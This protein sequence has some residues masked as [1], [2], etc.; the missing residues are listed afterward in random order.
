MTCL[1]NVFSCP[2]CTNNHS[3]SSN[4]SRLVCNNCIST[5]GISDK[6]GNKLEIVINPFFT[7]VGEYYSKNKECYINKRECYIIV[8]DDFN[9]YE[10]VCTIPIPN[11]KGILRNE[12][13]NYQDTLVSFEEFVEHLVK[14]KSRSRSRSKQV[15][16]K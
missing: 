1:I 12:Q 15:C 5:F 6:Y 9:N 8:S 4:Y 2:I 7:K 14:S 11:L 10:I 13:I 3:T 16:F